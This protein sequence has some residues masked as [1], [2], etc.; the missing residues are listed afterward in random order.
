MCL[1]TLKNTL[2]ND[3]IMDE[4]LEKQLYKK[5][6]FLRSKQAVNPMN[7]V[8][9]PLKKQTFIWDL[10]VFGLEVGNGWYPL[11]D[12]LCSKIQKHI[13]ETDDDFGFHA[14]QVK[15]KYAELRFYFE[16][17]DEYIEKLIR[18]AEKAS[19]H[20]C[21]VCGKEG[22]ITEINHWFQTLCKPHF[23]EKLK[24]RTEGL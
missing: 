22:E 4:K 18:N 20:I 10:M 1:K 14:V 23:K 24:A 8:M 19:V 11:L 2:K 15:E 21:E 17:G 13:G 9:K 3:D 5:Y 6:E 7:E 16:G 12:D